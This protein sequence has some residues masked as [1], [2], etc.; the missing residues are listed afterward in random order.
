MTA[1]QKWRLVWAAWLAAFAT[2]ETIATRSGHPHAPLSHHMRVPLRRN[3]K[4][5][6][7]VMIGGSAWLYR[8]IFNET[9]VTRD[10]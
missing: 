4:V 3:D 10:G 8:H 2:A 1:E 6:T 9:R 7:V 5:G